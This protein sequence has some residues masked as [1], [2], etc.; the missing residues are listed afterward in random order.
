MAGKEWHRGKLELWG[1]SI[2]WC[3]RLPQ[4]SPAET[5]SQTLKQYGNHRSD[6]CL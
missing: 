1:L 5:A 2:H 6:S 3:H 4:N